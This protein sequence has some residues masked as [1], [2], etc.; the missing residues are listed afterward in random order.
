MQA[1]IDSLRSTID[2]L[3]AE[4]A[5]WK[6][7]HKKDTDDY[8]DSIR[9]LDAWNSELQAELKKARNYNL[10]A[11]AMFDVVR[12]ENVL[13]GEACGKREVELAEAKAALIGKI[14]ECNRCLGRAVL[15]EASLKA[16]EAR[17]KALRE[18]LEHYAHQYCEGWCWCKDCPPNIVFDDCGGCKARA[19][20]VPSPAG[21]EG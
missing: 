20:L 15:A 12:S 17:E 4:L 14:E 21:R 11:Q 10:N 9:K 16:A 5:E 18:A 2:R 19:A 3:Q 1:E 7:Y 8:E 6:G 13:L